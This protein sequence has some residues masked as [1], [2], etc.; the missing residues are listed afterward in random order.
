MLPNPQETADLV[1][2]TKEILKTIQDGSFRS[3]AKKTLLP[4]ICQTD[5][6]LM[7][8]GSYTLL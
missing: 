4:K 5:P 2:F 3:Y 1:P 6:T 8:P 7:K